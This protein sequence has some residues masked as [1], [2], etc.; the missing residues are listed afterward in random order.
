MKPFEGQKNVKAIFK[1]LILIFPVLFPKKSLTL[2]QVGHAM[3]NAVA[4]GY[5]KQVLEIQ[6]I[7]KLADK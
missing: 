1:P 4:K 2:K 5:D 6:D 3:I 7:R